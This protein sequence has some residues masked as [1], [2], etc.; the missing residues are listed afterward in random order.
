MIK[1]VQTVK[2]EMQLINNCS[3]TNRQI[4]KRQ[5]NKRT[6]TKIERF[7]LEYSAQTITLYKKTSFSPNSIGGR[8]TP[9][10]IFILEKSAHIRTIITPL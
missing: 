7:S 6:D 1:Q 2:G 9:F 8:G 5:T 10:S 4:E 3:M